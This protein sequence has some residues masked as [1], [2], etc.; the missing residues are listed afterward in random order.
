[1]LP[2]LQLAEKIVARCAQPQVLC[3]SGCRKLRKVRTCGSSGSL[4]FL[5]LTLIPVVLV[6]IEIPQLI[7]D[8]VVDVLLDM[9][10]EFHRCRRGEDS[11]APT[12]PPVEKLVAGSS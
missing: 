2:Q 9:R 10:C 3:G 7:V 11:C 8:E 6:T 4:T 12:V 5:M 1:M